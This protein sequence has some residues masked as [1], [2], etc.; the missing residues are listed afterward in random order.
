MIRR[1]DDD[2]DDERPEPWLTLDMVLSP[3]IQT[4]SKSWNYKYKNDTADDDDA[5]DGNDAADDGDVDSHFSFFHSKL[6]RKFNIWTKEKSRAL[7]PTLTLTSTASSKVT[8]MSLSLFL[9]FHIQQK[10]RL[11]ARRLK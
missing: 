1:K 10:V 5:D 11:S 3:F 9:P 4:L 2:D 6:W 8:Q 7:M